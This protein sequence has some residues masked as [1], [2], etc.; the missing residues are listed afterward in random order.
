MR[1][2][3]D[4]SRIDDYRRFLQVKR[5]PQYRVTGR[6]V[7][8]PDEYADRIGIELKESY[9]RQAVRNIEAARHEQATLL[10][11]VES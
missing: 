7:W 5:L 11:G 10:D 9:Y 1:L 3:F 6:S 2:T 4:P 8:F